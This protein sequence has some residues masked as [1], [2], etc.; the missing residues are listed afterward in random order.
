MQSNNNKKTIDQRVRGKFFFISFGRMRTNTY[1]TKVEMD[2]IFLALKRK[3]YPL[4]LKN[5]KK[6][7]VKFE[8][9][10]YEHVKPLKRKDHRDIHTLAK[11]F[12][13]LATPEEFT[14]FR[15]SAKYEE[16]LQFKLSKNYKKV[17]DD[18]ED[19]DL[20]PPTRIDPVFTDKFLNGLELSF[21][22]VADKIDQELFTEFDNDNNHNHNQNS[23]VINEDN[24]T[25]STESENGISFNQ[26]TPY[27]K[28]NGDN[29]QE[30][31]ELSQLADDQILDGDDVPEDPKL[32]RNKREYW[33]QKFNI[34]VKIRK[35]E[36]AAAL[37]IHPD[38]L[39]N[40]LAHI[41][42]DVELIDQQ[43]TLKNHII[44][45]AYLNVLLMVHDC[46]IQNGAVRSKLFYLLNIMDD[47]DKD[48][49]FN[50]YCKASILKLQ[51]AGRVDKNGKRIKDIPLPNL[52]EADGIVFN[53]DAQP[54][55]TNNNKYRN[56]NKNY[57]KQ[58]NM[59]KHGATS[60]NYSSKT[61][62]SFPWTYT[63]ATPSISHTNKNV[64]KRSAIDANL[65]KGNQPPQKQHNQ[66]GSYQPPVIPSITDN[67][68][69]T[70]QTNRGLQ[71]YVIGLDAQKTAVKYTKE[72]FLA[73]RRTYNNQLTR[74][75]NCSTAD[76]KQTIEGPC[77]LYISIVYNMFL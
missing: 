76:F 73:K 68:S 20:T 56:H 52:T 14:I 59:I 71:Y 22:D 37:S 69:L 72:A 38:D 27:P 42:P 5:G 54:F 8:K 17:E 61:Y 24:E 48:K 45:L 66:Y 6:D 9:R 50:D 57:N 18:A 28:N 43:Y 15:Q 74:L 53:P 11:E 39:R 19:D 4:W 23:N 3:D 35:L 64:R 63:P 47:N 75:L 2:R 41:P 49:K 58:S 77:S 26:Q 25:K 60:R 33:L 32:D 65:P 55:N 70:N 30:F 44:G 29:V 36:H 34:I 51:F 62:Q 13:T 31:N 1:Y 12:S 7:L 40:P 67:E 16:N 46:N 10:Y 21:N